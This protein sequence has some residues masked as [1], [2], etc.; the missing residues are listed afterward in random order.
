MTRLAALLQVCKYLN[1]LRNLLHDL[2]EPVV[3]R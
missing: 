3:W 2:R 1:D